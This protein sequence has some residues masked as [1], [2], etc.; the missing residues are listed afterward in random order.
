M[1][2]L[3]KYICETNNIKP[4][5]HKRTTP[6][7]PLK[8]DDSIFTAQRAKLNQRDETLC[9]GR[10]A[11]CNSTTPPLLSPLTQ[12]KRGSEDLSS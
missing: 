11:H 12:N 2:K 4:N 5:S 9:K 3:N 7:L 8:G 1:M 6:G 10:T